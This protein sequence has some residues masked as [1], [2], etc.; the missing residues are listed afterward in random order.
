VNLECER[1]E[2]LKEGGITGKVDVPQL[3]QRLDKASWGATFQSMI[4]EP[5][6]LKLHLA[7]GAPPAT[8]QKPRTLD[9]APLMRKRQ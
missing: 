7:F 4:F 1:Y 8:A 6:S 2:K 9:L 3:W 5:A